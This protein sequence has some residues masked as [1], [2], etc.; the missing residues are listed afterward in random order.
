MGGY[1]CVD[2]EQCSVLPHVDGSVF[3]LGC[4]P[5]AVPFAPRVYGSMTSTTHHF[6]YYVSQITIQTLRPFY[7]LPLH[8]YTHICQWIAGC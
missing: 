8:V 3:C 2:H 4:G 5:G 1:A 7:F 6:M